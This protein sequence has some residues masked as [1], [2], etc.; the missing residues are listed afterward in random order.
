MT[1]ISIDASELGKLAGDLIVG[2]VRV[3]AATAARLRKSA[4][5]IE[6]LSQQLVRVRT[7]ALQSS[8]SVTITGDGRSAVMMAEI[9]PTT[10]YGIYQEVGKSVMA[11]Q[12]FMGPALEARAGAF[13]AA[14]EAAAAAVL[15]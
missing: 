7:G 14:V 15:D 2:G 13:V 12:P 1:S 6:T 11:P 5:E 3:G 4:I 9:G 8:I 10:P